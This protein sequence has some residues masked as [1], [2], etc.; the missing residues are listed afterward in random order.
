MFSFNLNKLGEICGRIGLFIRFE[1]ILLLCVC[2]SR[3][4]E[5]ITLG[6][7]TIRGKTSGHTLASVPSSWSDASAARAVAAPHTLDLRRSLEGSGRDCSNIRG[8]PV[9]SPAER[10][11]SIRRTIENLR[12]KLPQDSGENEQLLL[13]V[14]Q[15]TVSRTS[16]PPG[17]RSV[18][19]RTPDTS[20]THLSHLGSP[21]EQ[22]LAPPSVDLQQAPGADDTGDSVFI[23]GASSAFTLPPQLSSRALPWSGR[24]QPPGPPSSTFNFSGDQLDLPTVPGTPAVSGRSLIQ[25]GSAMA[26]EAALMR[27]LRE[28]DASIQF[29]LRSMPSA[30]LD[31][32]DL[33]PEYEENLVK[34]KNSVQDLAVTVQVV[35]EE[36]GYEEG[37]EWERNWGNRLKVAEA[38]LKTYRKEVRDAIRRIGSPVS[39]GASIGTSSARTQGAAGG[40]NLSS[41]STE[42]SERLEF[43]RQKEDQRK[44]RVAAEACARII[45]INQ[46]LTE[47]AD[48][49]SDHYNWEDAPD[50]DVEA[51]MG[52]IK[53]WKSSMARCT[54]ETA[55]L[56]GFIRG[57][58]IAA[59]LPDL[60]RL[61]LHLERTS[62]DLERAI[63]EIKEA[64][65][66]KGLYTSRKSKSDAVQ[67]PTF[68]GTPGEDFVI[69]QEKFKR[70]CVT[71]QI[72]RVDQVEK[73]REVLKGRAKSQVPERTDSMDRAWELLD[74]AFG[75]PMTLLKNR[76]ETLL[77]LGEYP[78]SLTKSNPQKIVDWCLQFER[79]IDELMKLGSRNERL[80]REAFCDSNVNAVVDLFPTR[81]LFKMER[82]PGS[83]LERLQGIVGMVEEERVVIQR[84]ANRVST[85]LQPK[86]AGGQQEKSSSRVGRT[87][88]INPKG[89]AVFRP[90]KKLPGCR[91][92]KQLELQGDNKDLYDDHHGNFPTGCP[93]WAGMKNEERLAIA[94]DAKFCLRCMD[95]K[96]FFD[97]TNRGKH[98]CTITQATKN[99][100][101][102]SNTRCC[103]HCWVCTN[104]K[105]ENKEMLQKFS[106]ELLKKSMSFVFLSSSIEQPARHA[107]AAAGHHHETA[108]LNLEQLM[109]E[110]GLVS[111]QQLGVEQPEVM[112]LESEVNAT[113]GSTPLGST[114]LGSTP[115]GSVSLP[116]LHSVSLPTVAPGEDTAGPGG[117][118]YGGESS[119]ENVVSPDLSLPQAIEQLKS[120]TP[121]GE[122]LNTTMKDSPLFM[123]SST[124]GSDGSDIKIFYDTGNSHVLFA[125][126]VPQK[127][128][129]VKTKGGP[130]PLGAVGNTTVWA[131]EE[132]ACQILMTSGLREILWGVTVPQITSKFPY[133]PLNP[134]VRAVKAGD[135]TN[136]ELQQLKIPKYVGGECH[137]LLGIQYNA[138]YPE[139]VHSLESG[140]AIYRLRIK[141]SWSTATIAGPH[142]SFNFL[143]ERVGN[144]A[145]LLQRFTEGIQQWRV[146]GA[147][148][149]KGIPMTGEELAF[150]ARMNGGELVTCGVSNLDVFDEDEVDVACHKHDGLAP[151]GVPEV[152]HHGDSVAGDCD[153]DVPVGGLASPQL[154]GASF[155]CT[156]CGLV[157]LPEELLQT[158]DQEQPAGDSSIVCA[159]KFGLMS[160]VPTQDPAGHPDLHILKQFIH[161]QTDPLKIDYRC[162]TCRN[163]SRCRNSVDTE[164]ISLREEA[165]AQVIMDSVKLDYSKKRFTCN[166]PLRGKE[167]DFLSSNRNAALKVLEKQCKVYSAEEDTK[168]MIVKAMNKLFDNGHAVLWE[169]LTQ[170]QKNVVNAKKV[171]YF[172]PW[173]VAFKPNS[174]STPARP[175]F[176]CSSKTPA[177]P[178]GSGGRC[179]N[180]LMCKGRPMSFQLIK[181]VLRFLIGRC[182]LSGDIRQFYNCFKLIEEQWNLQ[183]FLWKDNLDVEAETK[184]GVITTLIYGNKASAPQSEE[185]IR[186]LASHLETINPALSSFLIDS[187]YVDDV[188]DSMKSKKACE[189]LKV[190]TDKAFA[191]LGMAVKGWA[192]SGE[193]PPD[194]IAVDGALGVGGM[195]WTPE[196]DSIELRYSPLHFGKV[197]RGRLQ[198]DTVILE[199]KMI[200]LE[201]M[202][203]F[204]PKNLTKRM[205]TSKFLSVFDV[206]GKLIPLTSRMKRD[207][208][209]M[210]KD[211]P[212]WDEA[213]TNEHRTSWVKNFWELE[214]CRGL[215]FARPRM[216]VNAINSKMRL[217]VCVDAAPEL[218]VIWAGVGFELSTGEWSSAYLVGRCLLAPVDSTIPKDEL[219]AL[220]AGSN[221]CWVVRNIL[222]GWVDTYILA[223]DAQIPLFWILSEKKRLGL[224]HRSR[225]AQ[226]KRGTDLDSLFHIKTEHNVADGPTRP[227][228]FNMG[229]DLGPGSRWEMGMPWMTMKIEDV[230]AEGILTPVTDLVLK[231]EDR[232]VYE[233]GFVFEKTP[234]VLTQGHQVLAQAHLVDRVESVAS[235]ALFSNYLVEP[236]KM[237]FTKMVRVTAIVAKFC[238][239][240][241]AKYSRRPIPVPQAA[242]PFQVF[243]AIHPGDVLGDSVKCVASPVQVNVSVALDPAADRAGHDSD[244]AG[245]A[246]DRAGHDATT[247]DY[248][249]SAI[250]K[251]RP[252]TKDRV[253]ATTA[254]DRVCCKICKK[255]M[256]A[257]SIVAHVRN[258]H[259]YEGKGKN[260]SE[261]VSNDLSGDCKL[262]DP[263]AAVSNYP[264]PVV[265][266]SLVEQMGAA[267]SY[268]CGK[269]AKKAVKLDEEDLQCALRYLYSTAT[270]EVEHFA[271]PGVLDKFVKKDGI[272]YHKNRVNV[273]QR[274]LQAAELDG[275]DI[276]RAQGINLLTPI[277][278]R[279]SPLAYSIA[280]HIHCNIAKHK[281]FET[282][283][284]ISHGFV[285]IVS[286]FGLFQEIGDDCASCKKLRKKFLQAAM[287]PV[288]PSKFTISPPFWVTQG[289]LWGPLTTYVPG[290]ERSTRNKAALTAVCYAMVF[291]CCVSKLVNIQI[292]EC[293]SVKG[294][295]DGIT[296]LA[297]EQGL[298]AHFLVDQESALMKSLREGEVD[299]T[300]L[301]HEIQTSVNVSFAVCPVTGHNAHGLVERKIQSAQVALEASGAGK[302]RLHAT[303]LQTLAKLIESD[304][305]NM[306]LGLCYGRSETNTPLL[307]LLSPNMMRMGRINSRS[308]IGPFRLPSGPKSMMDRVEDCYKV[309]YREYQDTLLLKYLLD[310][311]PKWFKSDMVKLED[312]VFFR[313]REGKLDGD[314]TL[315]MVDDIV[316]SEDGVVRRVSV[317]Y[318]NSGEAHHRT[319]DRSVRKIV[320]LFNVEDGSWRQDMDS[321]QRKLSHAG[322]DVP[323]HHHH[324]YDQRGEKMMNDDASDEPSVVVPESVRASVAS[325]G[326]SVALTCD[327]CCQGHCRMVT[328]CEKMVIPDVAMA[329]GTVTLP[330]F[331]SSPV[332]DPP[333]APECLDLTVGD[334]A[335][336][337]SID[338]FLGMICAL[339]ME[340]S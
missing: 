25:V 334:M 118:N 151:V 291:V 164:K 266:D 269:V 188:N 272:L 170:A 33:I 208:R 5:A 63:K 37:D 31:S 76:K 255:E 145:A 54:R 155:S 1:V 286:A 223:G 182:A 50:K 306:P 235:R 175:V 207:L 83:G 161:S 251:D 210:V 307:K 333:N 249:A 318:Q 199:G 202:D 68:G 292:V 325:T 9:L 105:E 32:P 141:S 15:R 180:D 181:M 3:H 57:Y 158:V 337:E 275:L 26:D 296:R 194:D 115:L 106:S 273:G 24:F 204:V 314:W 283:V 34:L 317:R 71:N 79:I 305:N 128:Y 47:L 189:E 48:E 308:P 222:S 192:I 234:D 77:Q 147:P 200:S 301:Q 241:R 85:Q 154:G 187:R 256:S 108:Q 264:Q 171:H 236:T 205:I 258:V 121:A 220:V 89:Y 111:G 298:P 240:F 263:A 132:W 276:L 117:V 213:V 137:I 6:S 319:T 184:T 163:C 40:L 142:S 123:F 267:A 311:Q 86:K 232:K 265:V 219:E 304:L 215:K 13:S 52:E 190:A 93:R 87:N 310:L 12:D 125:E 172:I 282:C 332:F 238:R 197:S 72:P 322:V 250:A 80:E 198:A 60:D 116:R 174:L 279:Y 11:A 316:K 195:V 315:G 320:R 185:G 335:D 203:S 30:E 290:R 139:L 179:L 302:Q 270:K 285:F 303:G 229:T 268:Q 339:S 101:S 131:N 248:A 297:C 156:S 257:R 152:S 98:Q 289:D 70:A 8:S 88:M 299:I 330:D 166:L 211:T 122:R 55:E 43:D 160:G 177:K 130:F 217:I 95:P 53:T 293:K 91:V 38:N 327:C 21:L 309:W 294:L 225:V 35:M 140:L 176:D 56:E 231:D 109:Q 44:K 323:V 300:N 157:G 280:D 78:D 326:S 221:L 42:V 287:G 233:E 224:W 206:L 244:R 169:N 183:M 239:L 39:T 28:N 260:Y 27:K 162:P 62:R 46:S 328:H 245:H 143:A 216:P 104:H 196:V 150:A 75:D 261:T 96:V 124:K 16:S 100:Y 186:Q 277:I 74:S 103:F 92:C 107:A 212:S 19:T 149:P 144:T 97:P 340:M 120:L 59:L 329:A 168:K 178:D 191:S 84:I 288:H 90:P 242:V 136:L 237:S 324:D 114:P 138:F 127:L 61:K 253:T 201:E 312:V 82:L 45:T 313:K 67:L 126:G 146:S 284:R 165:E 81:L 167:D 41:A 295:C 129:G 243:H 173:R 331:A 254:K 112:V 226:V 214:R 66:E 22:A 102:C 10:E 73:L 64:D 135:P 49:F 262:P 278:D 18:I 4:I 271:K 23:F 252:A 321:V 99:R 110:R 228:L 58:D 7:S 209:R 119:N 51:A 193:R 69:F 338:P 65:E 17:R 227:D 281:G 20:P 274:F 259:G 29:L 153:D 36:K 133:V 247:K 336:L 14:L 148:A 134:A 246:A 113:L 2:D 159:D 218:V 94:K 230:V